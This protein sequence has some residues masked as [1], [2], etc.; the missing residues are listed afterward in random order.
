MAKNTLKDLR[1][2]LFETL[3]A[4][5]DREKPMEID[6]AKAICHAAQTIINSARVEVQYM[7]V[8]N[9]GEKNAEKFFGA[10]PVLPVTFSNKGRLTS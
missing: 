9:Q 2:H 8:T 10:E 5:S 1:D 3:E 7:Q 6:R 4:L